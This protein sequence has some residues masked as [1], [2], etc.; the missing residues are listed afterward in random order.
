MRVCLIMN[1]FDSSLSYCAGP[2]IPYVYKI[3]TYFKIKIQPLLV[4]TSIPM[5]AFCFTRFYAAYTLNTTNYLHVIPI[6]SAFISSCLFF[7]SCFVRIS[8]TQKSAPYNYTPSSC[9]WLLLLPFTWETEKV[10][11]FAKFVAQSVAPNKKVRFS[12]S[13]QLCWISFS[14]LNKCNTDTI[15]NKVLQRFYLG[16]IK[17]AQSKNWAGSNYYERKK[18]KWRKKVIHCEWLVKLAFGMYSYWVRI[19]KT[20]NEHLCI[21]PL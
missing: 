18:E 1:A 7:S 3:Y 9:L 4:F 14:P 20:T 15:S 10:V 8:L 16:R 19:R 5:Q 17:R 13:Y 6:H 11:S 21:F 2:C 12:I